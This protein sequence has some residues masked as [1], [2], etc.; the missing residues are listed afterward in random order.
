MKSKFL[1]LMARRKRYMREGNFEAADK[2]LEAA[3]KMKP[4]AEELKASGLVG[5]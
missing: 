1:N 5:P 2:L 4:S 3:R